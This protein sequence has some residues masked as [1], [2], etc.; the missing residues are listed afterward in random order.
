M[1][2]TGS[3]NLSNSGLIVPT[4]FKKQEGGRLLGQG[5][6][7]CTF[8]P[9]PRC[10]GGKV[11]SRIQGLPAVGKVTVED[12]TDELTVGRAIMK[13]PLA[14]QY[15]ALPTEA[16][17]PHEPVAD[18]DAGTCRFMS[19]SDDA[20]AQDLSMMVLPMAGTTLLKWS[21]TDQP[22]L[23]AHFRR[24]FIHLLEGMVIYQRAGY[25]HNDIHMDNILV[26]GAGVARY[27]DF[28]LAFKVA[29][30]KTWQDANLGRSFKPKYVW[31]PPEVHL[32]RMLL[33]GVRVTDGVDQLKEINPEYGQMEHQF[34]KQ[35]T[36]EIA[37]MDL[38]RTS[39]SIQRKDG[40]AFV[41]AYGKRFDSW[42]IGLCMWMIWSDLLAWP[43]FRQT[44]LWSERDKI[45]EVM[46]GLT[47]FDP[48]QRLTAEQAL[49]ALDPRNRLVTTPA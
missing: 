47:R 33:N 12:V 9:A 11:F 20:T 22:R 32:W 28:G 44:A 15:F 14:A 36:A 26:D 10:A 18:S 27:I 6:Y 24:L 21:G 13:L 3:F 30:V 41:R 4:R 23:A 2:G 1:S 17:K 40:G 45:R 7:G 49:A 39:T 5:V 37:M 42:R 38:A 48:R 25:V 34:P 16:C 19:E 35:P 43:G 29:D 8:E 46:G 31:Q